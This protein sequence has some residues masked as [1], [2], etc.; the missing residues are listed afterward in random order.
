MRETAKAY[1]LADTDIKRLTALLPR[2]WHPDPRRRERATV[3]EIVARTGDPREREVIR[4]AYGILGQPH[5]LSVH[6]GGLVITPGPLT[7]IV[8]VQWAPKGFLITQFR[9]S[10]C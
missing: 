8:P 1:G 9:S 6:P 2:E 5:H 7:D 4:Q 3:E 10:G